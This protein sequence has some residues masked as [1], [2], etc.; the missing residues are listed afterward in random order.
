MSRV[1]TVGMLVIVGGNKKW[2]ESIFTRSRLSF[3][4]YTKALK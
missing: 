2:V 3:S 4:G 1:Q